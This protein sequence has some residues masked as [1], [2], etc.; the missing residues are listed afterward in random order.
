LAALKGGNR[1]SGKIKVL[2]VDDEAQFR[3]TTEKILN[4]RGFITLVAASGEAALEMLDQQPDVVVLD[5]KMPGMDGHATLEEIRKRRPALPVIMLTGH[6]SLPS[7]REA[8]MQGACDYLAKPCDI[9]ILAQK[10]TEAHRRAGTAV[11]PDEKRVGD[12]MIP[13]NEYTTISATETVAAAIAKLRQS[14]GPK[15][16]TSRILETGHR[17]LLVFDQKGQLIGILAILD[18]LQALLPAY[19]SAPKPSTADSI[20]YS[21][22]FWAGM[23]THEV[24]QIAQRKIQALMSP[25]PPEIQ[26]DATLMEASFLMVNAKVRRMVVKEGPQL[27]GV[28]REQDLFFEIERL[29]R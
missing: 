27:V 1:M 20:H 4:R 23:F 9:D 25:A 16:S 2:M 19:L 17:S 8:L 26:S 15:I 24:R 3:A 28:I 29:T 5:I 14:F 13:L 18:L 11:S 6:G 7:A 10:I 21:P 22:L 12:V